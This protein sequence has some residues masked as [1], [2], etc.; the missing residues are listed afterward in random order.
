M[1]SRRFE[2]LCR[3]VVFGFLHEIKFPRP[4]RYHT[5]NT[6]IQQ[7]T[8]RRFAGEG[9]LFVGC[10]VGRARGEWVRHLCAIAV[11]K[12]VIHEENRRSRCVARI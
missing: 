6:R 1:V 12:R 11:I 7:W 4:N 8:H 2:S 3:Q 5:R 10:V 9:V